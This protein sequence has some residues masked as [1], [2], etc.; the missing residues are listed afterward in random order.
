[1]RFRTHLLCLLLVSA[2]LGLASCSAEPVRL[3]ELREADAGTIERAAYANL[4]EGVALANEF[5]ARSRFSRGFPAE[6]ASFSLGLNDVLLHLENEGIEELRIET[7]G[8]GDPRL[9]FGD[10]VHPTEHGFLSARTTGSASTGSDS[11]DAA[12]LRLSP[13]Q[14]AAVLLRQATTMREIQA[15]G[16]LDYWLNYDLLG[17]NPSS[18]WMGNNVVDRRAHAVEAAFFQWLQEGRPDDLSVGE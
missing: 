14:M 6:S 16:E 5:L 2:A 3:V 18:G 10:G 13:E 4:E 11:A 9:I 17:L 12:F 1:M 15:R 8:W 7:A